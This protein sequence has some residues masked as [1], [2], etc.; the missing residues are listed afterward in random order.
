MVNHDLR[1]LFGIT[2]FDC[3]SH[4]KKLIDLLDDFKSFSF[5]PTVEHQPAKSDRF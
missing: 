4:F 1:Q 2:C 3:G 5:I